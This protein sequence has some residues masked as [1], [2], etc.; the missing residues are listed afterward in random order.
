M[1]RKQFQWTFQL[2][3]ITTYKLFQQFD[4]ELK[5]YIAVLD[6]WCALALASSS[7]SDE[8]INFIFRL[9]D[10]N[11][12]DYLNEMELKLIIRCATR[13]FSY[14]KGII[15]VP[16]KLINQ[17]VFEAFH[18]FGVVL[19]EVGEISLRDLRPYLLVDDKPRTY[20]ANL[21]TLIVIE[22]SSKLI[23]QRAELLKELAEIEVELQEV[24][25]AYIAK[26]SDKEAYESER[27]GDSH[28][29]RLTEKL[30]MDTTR[31]SKFNTIQYNTIYIYSSFYVCFY[32][33]LL[34]AEVSHDPLN[35]TR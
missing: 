22:D 5:G 2:N 19:N 32:L 29:V 35:L 23:E 33:F 31:Q 7:T 13:G 28:L 15:H 26:L 4:P 24:E 20:F 1:S 16:I 3:D 6:L 9:I 12:D 10:L 21:G 30:L 25:S 34:D 18:R 14:L 27:G 11:H 17:V 8:K